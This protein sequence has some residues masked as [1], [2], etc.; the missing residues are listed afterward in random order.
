MRLLKSKKGF[1]L[2]EMALVI[3]CLSYL[4]VSAI[5]EDSGLAPISLDS[6]ARKVKSDLRYAQSMA[7]TTG[8]S[9]GLEVTGPNT[10]RIYNV[11]TNQTITSPYDNSAMTENLSTDYGESQFSAQNYLVIFDGL[12]RP[13]T[14]GGSSI[15]LQDADNTVTKEIQISSTSGF[16]SLQ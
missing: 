2:I 4:A 3:V 7:T 16:V 14:G 5:P 1:T 12:G 9:H 11:T 8:D 10:Y 15:F 6:A 13:T